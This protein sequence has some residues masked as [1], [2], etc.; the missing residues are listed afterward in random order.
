MNYVNTKHKVVLAGKSL[1]NQLNM[2]DTSQ[3]LHLCNCLIGSWK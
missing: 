1:N 3:F 2:I